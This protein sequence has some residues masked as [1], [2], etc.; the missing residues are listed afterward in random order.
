[1]V[2]IDSAAA[3]GL[4]HPT[5]MQRSIEDAVDDA[6]SGGRAADRRAGVCKDTAAITG[7]RSR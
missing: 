2:P 4:F 6:L 1:M 3:R 5:L 7:K